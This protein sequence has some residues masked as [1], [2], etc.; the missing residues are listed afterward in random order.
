MAG[1]RKKL[2][3]FR[4]HKRM[5]DAMP[6]ATIGREVNK[7]GGVTHGFGAIAIADASEKGEEDQQSKE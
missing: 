6:E 5:V 1:T 2:F 3:C 4:A 7:W